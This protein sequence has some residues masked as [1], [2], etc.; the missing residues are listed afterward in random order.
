MLCGALWYHLLVS[1]SPTKTVKVNYRLHVVHISLL[2][3]LSVH[4]ALK[5]HQCKGRYR[6]SMAHSTTD[7]K[8]PVL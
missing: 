8:N 5:S 1:A 4:E 7:K 3:E 6:V 2:R